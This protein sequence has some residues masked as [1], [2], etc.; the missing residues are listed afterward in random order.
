MKHLRDTFIIAGMLFMICMTG[1]GIMNI[2]DNNWFR[3]AG[4]MFLTG[5]LFA[6][7]DKTK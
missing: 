4:F 3:F 1:V 6:V 2:T 7:T 5:F